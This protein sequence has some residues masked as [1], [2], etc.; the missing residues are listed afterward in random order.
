VLAYISLDKPLDRLVKKGIKRIY[1]VVII[2][3][4]F[5]VLVISILYF[6]LPPLAQ[7][8]GD[9]STSIPSYIQETTEND[10]LAINPASVETIR[11]ISSLSDSF[12]RGSQTITGVLL[13]VSDG[14][15]TF[16][17]VFFVSLFLNLPEYGVRHLFTSFTPKKHRDYVCKLYDMIE[18]RVGLWLW[19]KS[20]SSFVVGCFIFVGL[21]IIGIEYAI[22]FAIFAAFLNFIPFI[23]PFIASLFPLFLGLLI[24][25]AHAFAVAAL[26]FAANSFE[27]FIIIPT[28]MKHS[29]NLNPVLLIF[30]VLVGGKIS[31]ILGV[32]IAI[33]VAAILT[34]AYEEYTIRTLKTDQQQLIT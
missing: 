5:F 2:Y 8:L 31:G 28:L 21:L 9:L 23:G 26:F 12:V 7:E 4:A 24:S 33:P 14:F 29:I 27:N 10:G 11:Y 32:L 13:K 15:F 18:N 19:G 17:V 6:L 20:V 16:L 3:S 25:P 34:L 22:T 1:G 30:V